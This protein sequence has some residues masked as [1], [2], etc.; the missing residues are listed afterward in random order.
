MESQKRSNRNLPGVTIAYFLIYV[1]WGSTYF[2]IGVALKDF[3]PF[4][5][6]ALRFAAAELMTSLGF[7]IC[8]ENVYL[9]KV[10]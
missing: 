5:L 6:G 10:S 1:V 8:G 3:S 9:R 7:V 2:F 4:L